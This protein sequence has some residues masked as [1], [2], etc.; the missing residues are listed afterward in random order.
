MFTDLLSNSDVTLKIVLA[1]TSKEEDIKRLVEVARSQKH[2][3]RGVFHVAGVAVDCLIT[4]LNSDLFAKGTGPK[5]M[6]AWYLHKETLGIDTIDTFVVISSAAS[7]SAVRGMGAYSAANGFLD[8]LVRLRRSLGLPGTTFNMTGL[9]DVG[10]LAQDVKVRK[11]HVRSGSHFI[12]AQSA[13]DDLSNVLARGMAEAQQLWFPAKTDMYG[14]HASC[15]HGASKTLIAGL[16][17]VGVN[18]TPQMV[19]ERACYASMIIM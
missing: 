13:L 19:S 15:I 16:N 14:S 3:I 10:I 11:V 18:L 8:A 6:G 17:N 12:T 1:D 2:P 9:S 5:A 7:I 4:E